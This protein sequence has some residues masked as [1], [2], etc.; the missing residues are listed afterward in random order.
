MHSIEWPNGHRFA[1]SIF[2]DPDSQS[3]ECSRSVYGFLTEQGFRTTKGVWPLEATREAS[4]DGATCASAEYR[5]HCQELQALGFEI[6]LHNATSH[7]S[8]REETARGLELFREYFGAAPRTMA[9]HYHS[10]EGIYFGDARLS[11][12]R[13]P[14]YN[15]LTR[16]HNR[17]RYRG[18]VEGDELFW[19]DLCRRELT[20]VRN[21]VFLNINTLAACPEM[22]YHDPT[23]PYVR[24]WYASSSGAN[25]K[26]F[27]D[28]LKEKNQDRLEA[29]GGACIVYTHFAHGYHENGK[30][31]PRF[32][33]L[34]RRLAAKGGWYVP[35]GTLLDYIAEK[36]GVTTLTDG[37]RA[38]LERRWLAEKI[39]T[40]TS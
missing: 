30:L 8:T 9:N 1:F 20:Y 14:L 31:S 21:F 35:V 15:V 11:G 17:R 16:A 33:E 3:L 10:R 28:L 13:R 2:D 18:H 26:L 38:R 24:R 19:G 25:A 23:K 40:G 39:R 27:L 7:T 5:K 37:A 36:R 12:W 34:M 6:G 29:E 4:D 32:S 22:P